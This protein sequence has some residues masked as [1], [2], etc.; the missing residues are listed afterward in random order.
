[1]SDEIVFYTNPRSRGLIAA[2]MLEELGAPY[3]TEILEFDTTMKGPDYLRVNPMGKVPAIRHRGQVVTE[4]AAICLYL[5]DAFPEAGLLPAPEH[6]AAYFRWTVF[7][8]GPF[9][10]ATTN[11]ALGVAVA[12]EQ[13]RMMGYGA[14][15]EQ[16]LDALETAL[17]GDYIAGPTFS[18]ADVYV[19][20]QL[21][22]QLQFGLVPARPA[23]AAYVERLSRRPAFQRTLG[24]VGR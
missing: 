13:R 5:A 8:A 24:Q 19:G 9:E 4:A 17:E 22:W 15:V 10:Q 20:A 1:M 6:R 16:V 12:P 11:A 3:R 21:G 14:G 23:F 18:A 7:A 2:W